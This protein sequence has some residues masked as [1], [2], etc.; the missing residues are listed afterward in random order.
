MICHNQFGNYPYDIICSCFRVV[1][2]PEWHAAIAE[3]KPIY[4]YLAFVDMDIVDLMVHQTKL[5]ATQLVT[6][7]PNISNNARIHSR[8]LTIRQEIL[9]RSNRLYE[10]CKNELYS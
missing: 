8:E 4:Y 5:Y 10:N 2:K 9:L 6:E 3:N 7:N 1:I